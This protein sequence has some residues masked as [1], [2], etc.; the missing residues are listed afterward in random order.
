[1]QMK[2]MIAVLFFLLIVIGCSAGHDFKADTF[3]KEDMCMLKSDSD[4]DKICYGMARSD[5]EKILGAGQPGGFTNL[6][7]YDAGVSIFYRNDVVAGLSLEEGSKG[8]YRTSRGAEIGMTKADIKKLYGEKYAL[9]LAEQN[10]DYF[11]DSGDRKFLDEISIGTIQTPEEMISTYIFS[12]MFDETISANRI[13]LLD[14]RM[15]MHFE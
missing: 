9:E 13:M 12:A 11:Y 4:K 5:V 10:L 3:S 6:F 14:K 7:E 1:M 15:A 2:T 8:K